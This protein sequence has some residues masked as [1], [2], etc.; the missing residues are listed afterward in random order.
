MKYVN[1]KG[2]AEIQDFL[3]RHHRLAERFRGDC[4]M[5]KSMLLGWA[6]DA[7]FQMWEGNP[8]SIEIRSFD[9]LDG[10]TRTYTI[11]QDGISE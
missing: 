8:P 2:I 6:K 11:S 10:M 9:T 3:I 7:E 5:G 1:N 4:P